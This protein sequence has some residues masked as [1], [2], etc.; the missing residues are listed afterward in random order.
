M[1][2]NKAES[3]NKTRADPY[4]TFKN[5]HDGVSQNF[6]FF[7]LFKHHQKKNDI[8]EI[9][10]TP[11]LAEQKYKKKEDSYS[12]STPVLDNILAQ[13]LIKAEVYYGQTLV[14]RKC[15]QLPEG[16]TIVYPH[17]IEIIDDN[18]SDA[19][20]DEDS[21]LYETQFSGYDYCC[22]RISG[23]QIK[24]G[25][26][27]EE[28]LKRVDQFLG[29]SRVFVFGKP[30]RTEEGK[31]KYGHERHPLMIDE[32]T[33]KYMIFVATKAHAMPKHYALEKIRHG[34]K[35]D[36]VLRVP[37]EWV[38]SYVLNEIHPKKDREVTE[39]LLSMKG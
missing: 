18:D 33:G 10:E 11:I 17:R 20:D 22:A 2:T 5:S 21:N 29:N 8:G 23:D 16:Y 13:L 32:E 36:A 34:L 28:R 25:I 3:Y 6:E 39:K 9:I 35:A 26:M 4:I 31:T 15:G 19:S 27:D 24:F 14:D 1:T 7:N 12:D 37:R 38:E 30:Y